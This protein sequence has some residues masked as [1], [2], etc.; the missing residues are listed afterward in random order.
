RSRGPDWLAVPGC[1]TEHLARWRRTGGAVSD[2][3]SCFPLRA[4]VPLRCPTLL[5]REALPP[6]R[7][8]QARADGA[9]TWGR[10]LS[11]QFRWAALPNR[12]PPDDSNGQPCRK[13]R[14]GES[15]LKYDRSCRPPNSGCAP[16]P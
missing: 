6:V 2:R 10:K 13:E 14:S 15:A 16:P 5:Q 11:P 3:D 9:V 4:A 8:R 1:E 7:R 12:L